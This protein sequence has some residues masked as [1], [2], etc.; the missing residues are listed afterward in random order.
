MEKDKSIRKKYPSDVSIE[1]FEKIRPM[2]EGFKKR[3]K[4]RKV[5]LYEVFCGLLYL[6]RS[7]CQW[8][9]LPRDF[10]K[11]RTVYSYYE[12]WS[13]QQDTNTPS[14]LESVLKKSV[15]DMRI[16]LGRKEQTSFCI[17]D[18]QS[19]KNSDTAETKGYDAGKKVSGIKR[20]VAVD[21]NGLPH[22]LC[23]TTA[24]VTDRDG[25]I[26]M[27]RSAKA[28]LSSVTNVLVDGGYSGE[29]FAQSVKELIGAKVEV[30]KR[31]ELH[32]FAVIP[33]RWVVERCFAWLDKCRRLWKNCERKLNH[34]L[35]FMVLAFIA[36][37]IRRL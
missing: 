33:K 15:G 5:D 13:K 14:L 9:M 2:L 6:L 34:S 36:I 30:A 37:L 11:W 19:V 16:S 28:N 26:L 3:T 7:G 20:H 21:T 17:V 10:P 24:N 23:V 25:A 12:Q 22:A 18:A 27:F 31:N 8:R 35:Q 4:P 29:N 1:Q 32:K